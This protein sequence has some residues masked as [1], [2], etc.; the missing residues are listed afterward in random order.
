MAS[1]QTALAEQ[2]AYAPPPIDGDFYRIANVLDDG[3]RAL[4]KRVRDIRGRRGGA[5]DRGVLGARRISLRDHPEDG[6]GRHRRRRLRRI[7][8]GRR[9][10]AAERFCRDGA[11]AGRFVGR[12]VLGRA[13]RP[14]GRVDLSVRR[15]GAE[16]ALAAGHDALRED[17]LVRPDRTAGRLGDVGRDDDDLPARGRHRGF[18]TARRNGSATPPSPTST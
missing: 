17:R 8:R 2:P 14:F 1:P 7:W 3:E 11:G 6:R 16:A 10:L 9:Q 18:S 15:R 12:D 5:G 4:I 13:Y